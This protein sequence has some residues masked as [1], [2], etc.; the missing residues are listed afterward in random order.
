[1]RTIG[2]KMNAENRIQL[3]LHDIDEQNYHIDVRLLQLIL[4]NLISNAL[5]YSSPEQEVIVT[6]STSE[7]WL[8]F[9]VIDKGTGI[10]LEDRP[11]IFEPFYRG[12]NATHI[13]GT[14]IGLHIVRNCLDVYGGRISY[15][16]GKSGTHFV[17]RLPLNPSQDDA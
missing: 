17:V 16:T 11:H 15:T 13:P 5:N 9:N 14:G 4:S 3:D 7:E 10:A 8:V 12:S 2:I 6:L 1:M